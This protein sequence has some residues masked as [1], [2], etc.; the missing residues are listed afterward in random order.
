M[1]T[2]VSRFSEGDKDQKDLLGGKG[3]NLAE[4]T[5][6]GLP[7]P[8]AFA[9]PTYVC[10]LFHENSRSLPDAVWDEKVPVDP[11]TY[12]IRDGLTGTATARGRAELPPPE[13]P[14]QQVR[15]SA[16]PS[17][18]H[19]HTGSPVTTCTSR[20]TPAGTTMA[21][22]PMASIRSAQWRAVTMVADARPGI[23]LSL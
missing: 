9:L 19:P 7:V 20:G 8:P 17:A 10:G 16:A 13:P 23:T 21:R 3:A 5:N 14:A 12:V 15:P 6:L 2:Y 1:T 11:G 4:M 18:T 22:P